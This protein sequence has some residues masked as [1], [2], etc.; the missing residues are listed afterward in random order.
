MSDEFYEHICKG[1]LEPVLSAIKT[2]WDQ[3]TWVEIEMTIFPGL[4]KEFYDVRKLVSWI[5]YN[6]DE[7]VP[8]HFLGFELL[9]FLKKIF[10]V[11]KSLCFYNLTF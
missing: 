8:I 7:N 4:H 9:Y 6:L 11:L 3:V 10:P 5:L 2:A 1:K